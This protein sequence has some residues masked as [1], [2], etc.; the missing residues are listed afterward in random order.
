LLLAIALCVFSTQASAATLY[1]WIDADG[2]V[3]YSD[4][5]PA[6]QSDR[7]HQQLNSQGVVLTTKEAAKTPEEVAE[8]AEVNRKLE[9]EQRE[10]ARLKEIQ[11]QKDRV[12]LLTFGS[13][14]EIEHARENRIQ[15]IDSVI[16]LIEASI[17]KT[18]EK[19]E[20]LKRSA[21]RNYTDKGQ[22]IPGGH[23]QKI[24]HFERK[25]E[26]RNE[27]LAAKQEEKQKIR[28]KYEF[29]LERFRTL[30]SASNEQ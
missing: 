24:E 7:Q 15:V 17:A 11:D 14:E 28:Q 8:E 12:L 19:L 4:R 3:Q 25:I 21:E 22:E 26:I 13:E 29:D 18:Q 16:G 27:Q 20:G 6:D 30:K 9:E 23:A 1:K 5:L 10:E 2:K